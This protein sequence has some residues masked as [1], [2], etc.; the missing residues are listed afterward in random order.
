MIDTR[1]Y[2]VGQVPVDALAITV[3]DENE[4]ARDLSGYEGA[5]AL[6][7]GPDDVT[8]TGGTAAITDAV[9]GLVTFDWPSTTLFDVPGDYS[10]RLKLTAG[11]GTDYTTPIR[12][13]VKRGL[14]V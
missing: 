11:S 8:R 2:F 6:F 3:Q 12:V 10:L 9:N 5:S 13:V 7:I 1:T 4:E 14:E